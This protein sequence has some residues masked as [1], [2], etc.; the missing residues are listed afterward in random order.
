MVSSWEPETTNC[1]MTQK[2][3]N[4]GTKE[5]KSMCANGQPVTIDLATGR[6]A[7]GHLEVAS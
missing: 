7:R 5:I 3:V 4:K 2:R 6:K 1:T